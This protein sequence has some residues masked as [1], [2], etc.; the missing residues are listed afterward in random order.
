MNKLLRHFSF[1]LIA[2][3]LLPGSANQVIA[4]TQF[5][6]PYRAG[7]QASYRFMLPFKG[8]ATRE[9]TQTE[10]GQ[11][12]LL[13]RVKSP[14]IKLEE[15]SLFAWTENQPK[16]ISYL[17]QQS[18]LTK[19]RKVS[20]SFDWSN[21]LAI[22]SAPDEPINL[23]LLPGSLDKLNYQL[24]L[25]QDLSSQNKPGSY[26]VADRKRLKQYSFDLLGEE[27]LET[28]LGRFNTVKLKRSRGKDS[29]RET[30]FWLA[31]DWDYLL[32]KIQQKEN[33]KSYE[34]VMSEGE[35]DGTAI[36]GLSE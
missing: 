35:L 11:W 17:Y 5:I 7:Y 2:V 24:K 22:N 3:A 33:G 31:K 26:Y 9:L 10:N 1:G 29:S 8:T 21:M 18:G 6:K 12:Q 32:L 27:Q 30:I 34:I 23:K 20:L 4:D 25:R 28:P 19:K 13:H 36:K 15:S 14:M 16:P